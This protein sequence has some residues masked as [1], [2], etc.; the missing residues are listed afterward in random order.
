MKQYFEILE[1][2]MLGHFLPAYT[3][4]PKRRVIGA[5]K[6]YFADVGVVNHLAKRGPLEPGSELY[7]KAFES[8][9]MHELRAY[10]LYS[11]RRLDLA[12]WRLAGGTEVD[13]IVGAMECAIEAKATSRITSD[14]LRGL[15]SLFEDHPK[16]KRR[17]VV[18]LES[19]PRKTEDGIEILPALAFAERLWADALV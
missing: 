7:G 4:K 11:K 16:V 10:S 18:S 13:F 8:W 9:V 14:H 6:F 19:R 15:R 3:K 12:Y 1:D 5:P 17:V 2:T